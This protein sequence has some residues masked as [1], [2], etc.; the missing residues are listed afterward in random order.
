MM[1]RPWPLRQLENDRRES[2]SSSSESPRMDYLTRPPAEDLNIK[3]PNKVKK[4]KRQ[5]I[6]TPYIRKK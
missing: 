4:K 1:G 3:S 2:Q 5:R 6:K